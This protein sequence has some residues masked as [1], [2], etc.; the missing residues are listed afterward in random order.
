MIIKL[1]CVITL[2]CYPAPWA[3]SETALSHQNANNAPQSYQDDRIQ[4]SI[5]AHWS[6]KPVYRASDGSRS[7]DYRIGIV[8][9]DGPFDLYLL[10]HYKQA[11]GVIGGRFGEVAEYVVPWLKDDE[12][13]SCLDIFKQNISRASNE[14]VRADLILDPKLEARSTDPLC[15]LI[16]RNVS[17]RV[18][19]GAYFGSLKGNRRSP[20]FFIN[21]PLGTDAYSST[22]IQLVFA[23]SV[24]ATTPGTL[25]LA[26]DPRLRLFLAEADRVISEIIYKRSKPDK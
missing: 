20:G 6:S 14:L 17:R 5:P 2:A 21:T 11:S 3:G 25:P 13:S 24:R 9:S 19:A 15:S 22:G 16:Q 4:V 12:P 10:T 23:A 7:S 1:Y 18:W 8:L 26:N